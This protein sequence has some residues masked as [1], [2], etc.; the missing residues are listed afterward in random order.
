MR[1]RLRAHLYRLRPHTVQVGMVRLWVPA[2]VLDPVLF[3]SGTW[4]ARHVARRVQ[5][6]ERLLD[7]GCGSGVVG[8]LA[9]V[10]GASVTSSDINPRAVE[11]ARRNGILDVRQG[12]L[13]LPF[14]S[15]RFDRICFNPPYFT[16]PISDRGLDRAL[17]GGPKLEV[18]QR[19]LDRAPAH[20]SP[21]GEAWM[22]LSERAPEALR[23]AAAEGWSCAI[24][25]V[26]S[27]ERLSAWRSSRIR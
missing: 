18:M 6:G 24:E 11:A 4:F 25:E 17:H 5:P 2:G 12:D 21:S 7:L 10:A 20:L 1:E 3:R 23:L 15:E 14:Q 19:F 13:L 9:Q 16:G 22:V 26:V 27:G 8:V